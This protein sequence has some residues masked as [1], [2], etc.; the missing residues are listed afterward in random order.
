MGL[1]LESTQFP[2]RITAGDTVSW[3]FRAPDYSAADGWVMTAYFAHAEET[4]LAC[5]AT[6]NAD[7]TSFDFT[8]PASLTSA[9]LP[10][11]MTYHLRAVSADG[12][13]IQTAGYGKL[14][15]KAD[16]TVAGD[17]R[18]WAERCLADI[19]KAIRDRMEGT[20]LDEFT[21]AG[22]TSK[23]PSLASLTKLEAEFQAKVSMEKGRPEMRSIPVRLTPNRGGFVPFG[24]GR[25]F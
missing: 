14:R 10:G 20:I 11:V 15:V 25:R 17:K 19:R 21:M 1:P 4:P 16:P 7:G 24:F 13:Q 23:M 6:P 9:M 5:Q 2:T 8:L 3:M 22:V 12:T 18:T